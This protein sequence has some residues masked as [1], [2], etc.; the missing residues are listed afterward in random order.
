MKKILFVLFCSV[1]LVGCEPKSDIEVLQEE[2][3]MLKLEKEKKALEQSLEEEKNRLE[4]ELLFDAIED[5]IAEMDGVVGVDKD[6]GDCWNGVGGRSYSDGGRYVGEW[7]DGA[8]NGQGTSF[9]DGCYYV[10]EWKDGKFNGQ[11]TLYF[12]SCLLYT[13]PSPRD[14]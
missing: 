8:K 4:T 2:V 1:T 3:E 12:T 11:G 14:S 13:S 6:Y 9:M 5:I 10:G 7:K